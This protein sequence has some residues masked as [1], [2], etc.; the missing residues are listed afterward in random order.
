V[1]VRPTP[2]IDMVKWDLKLATRFAAAKVSRLHDL[3]VSE[4][5]S[6]NAVWIVSNG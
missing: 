2:S 6:D 5:H 3:R 4:V 1:I